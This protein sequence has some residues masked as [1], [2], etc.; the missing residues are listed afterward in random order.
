VAGVGGDALGGMH[1]DRVAE[2]HMI[3]EVVDVEGDADFVVEAFGG[4]TVGLCID[5]GD[6]RPVSVTNRRQ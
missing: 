3:A 4:N 5:G 2:A 6:P 1:G